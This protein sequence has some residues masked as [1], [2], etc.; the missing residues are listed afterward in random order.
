[1]FIKCWCHWFLVGLVAWHFI[2]ILPSY[3]EDDPTPKPHRMQ[4]RKQSLKTYQLQQKQTT[5]KYLS[6]L[7]TYFIVAACTFE[8]LVCF[9][10]LTYNYVELLRIS[11]L[12]TRRYCGNFIMYKF[13]P[14]PVLHKGLWPTVG[15][16][17]H[18]KS[19]CIVQ[20]PPYTWKYS[21]P[22]FSGSLIFK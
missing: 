6:K 13:M 4:L 10:T 1:M 9:L 14:A 11:S 17:V 8:I 12:A 22:V 20:T 5:M 18:R 2:P 19:Y 3:H 7:H 21:Q 15:H 16:L